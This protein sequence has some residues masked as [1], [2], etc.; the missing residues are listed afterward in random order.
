MER[1]RDGFANSASFRC[2]ST[3]VTL[4]ADVVQ[5]TECFSVT[6]SSYIPTWQAPI[7]NAVNIS[8]PKSVK[9]QFTDG[10]IEVSSV[11]LR[12]A[13]T[14]WEGTRIPSPHRLSHQI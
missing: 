8:I 4:F 5:R 9:V 11:L 7:I 2:D 6:K 13:S 10:T 3:T 1:P 14:T 12:G